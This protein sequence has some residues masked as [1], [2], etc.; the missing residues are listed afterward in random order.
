MVSE[1][2]EKLPTGIRGFD[3][4][5]HGGLPKKRTTLLAGT[6]GSAKTVFASQ[7]LAEGIRHFDQPGIF[8][9]F[10][11]SPADIRSNVLGLGW[12]VEEWEAAKAKTEGWKAA[13]QRAVDGYKDPL[14]LEALVQCQRETTSCPPASNVGSSPQALVPYR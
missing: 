3:H 8:V 4:V 13:V 12:T 14:S 6:A 11:E 2:L 7:F 10:E 1:Y 9:T 5:T